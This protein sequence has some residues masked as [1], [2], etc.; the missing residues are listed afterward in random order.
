M[1]KATSLSFK[2]Y[3]LPSGKYL[4]CD[5]STQHI[6]PYI[7]KKFRIKIFHQFHGLSHP[8]FRSTVKLISSKFIWLNIKR[9]VQ[10]WA[11]SC[12]P[13]Q[14]SKIT[15]HTKS[16]F[17]KFQKTIGRN[18]VNTY[19]Y[20]RSTTIIKGQHLLFNMHI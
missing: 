10:Q 3:P 13:Y 5:F 16:V 15:H 2:K 20:C 1:Q 18:L 11:K 8:R 9:Y 19:W 14:K 4:W 6:R 12:I 7:S 17:G